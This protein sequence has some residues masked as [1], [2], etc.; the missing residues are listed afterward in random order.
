MLRVTRWKPDTCSCVLYTKFDDSLDNPPITPVN[1]TLKN[2]EFY[3][4]V[5]PVACKYHLTVSLKKELEDELLKE[6]DTKKHQEIKDKSREVKNDTEIEGHYLSVVKE[7][8]GVQDAKS[9][10]LEN[11][12]SIYTVLSAED[13][14]LLELY[15]QLKGDKTPIPDKILRSDVKI[16]H[17]FDEDRNLILDLKGFTT[18]EKTQADGLIKSNTKLNSKVSFK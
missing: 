5:N 2:G 9:E 11:V 12:E 7:N 15:A 16:E 13:K 1:Y 3:E 17:S 8:S 10:I 14:R 4:D 18:S 6:K